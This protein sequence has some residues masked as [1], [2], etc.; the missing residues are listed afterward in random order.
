MTVLAQMAPAEHAVA[1]TP[2]DDNDLASP[3]NA[4][5]IG[6]TGDVAVITT[7]G[8]TITFANVPV[9]ILPVQ[10]ARVLEATTATDIV[11]MW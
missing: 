8:D 3:S 10:V 9:G 4:L 2:D 7:G 5:Y 6:T 11:A 1:V